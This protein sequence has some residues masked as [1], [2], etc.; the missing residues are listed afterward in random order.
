[1]AIYD[2]QCECGH[3]FE[4]NKK[5]ADRDN[6][7]ADVCPECQ[8][9]GKITRGVSAPIVGYST[10]VNGAGKPPEGFREV[11]RKI[12]KRAPGSRLDKTSSFL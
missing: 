3:V 4:M 10:H 12:H 2:Y 9:T 11:L 1:M 6:T 8:Q 7:E 5:I